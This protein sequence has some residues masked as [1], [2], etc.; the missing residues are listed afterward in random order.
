MDPSRTGT[1][2]RSGCRNIRQ[3]FARQHH[4][5]C[6]SNSASRLNPRKRGS[7]ERTAAAEVSPAEN[8]ANN[9][10]PMRTRHASQSRTRPRFESRCK[11]RYGRT[12]RNK[13]DSP[14]FRTAQTAGR[15]RWRLLCKFFP[16][17]LACDRLPEPNP[18]KI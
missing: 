8:P 6:S 1:G 3:G 16:D 15:Q 10:A 9:P 12:A 2:I 17:I 13:P 14:P 7:A 4:S 11:S 5:G 18:Q